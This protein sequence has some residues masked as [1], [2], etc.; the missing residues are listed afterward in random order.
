MTEKHMQ[1]SFQTKSLFFDES[2]KNTRAT[3]YPLILSGEI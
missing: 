1:L 3:S 2:K